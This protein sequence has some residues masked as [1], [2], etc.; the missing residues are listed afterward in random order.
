M[1]SSSIALVLVLDALTLT[2]LSTCGTISLRARREG[3]VSLNI[4]ICR[5]FSINHVMAP[6]GKQTGQVLTLSTCPCLEISGGLQPQAFTYRSGL[7]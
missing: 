2:T 3:C 7:G 4:S 5:P 6:G 1:Y